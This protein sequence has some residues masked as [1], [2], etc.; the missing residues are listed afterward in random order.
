MSGMRSCGPW[1]TSSPG[2]AE[3]DPVRQDPS[4][5]RSLTPQQ[6]ETLDLLAGDWRV[7]QLR[8]GHRFSTDDLVCAWF[9]A[10]AAPNA[11][12]LLDLG[13][14]V[15]SVGLLALWC[16]SHRARLPRGE[17]WSAR[18]GAP[19]T[20]T[21][22]EAQDISHALARR[23][24]VVNGLSS[25]VTLHLAD[26]RSDATL[27]VGELF[28]LV[29]GSPP[30]IPVGSGVISAHP[31][32]A[33]CRMELR[34]DVSDYCL[35]AARV[36]APDG[37]FSLVHAYGDARPEPSLAA[38]GLS[39]LRRIDVAFRRGKA[40][41]I[42]VFVAAHQG[43]RE[44]DQTLVVREADGSWTDAWQTLRRGMGAPAPGRAR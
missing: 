37:R 33:A 6:G 32:R 10:Q 40:P 26:L 30:Y 35:A 8:A 16:V 4:G 3:V 5:D 25:R 14:G 19:P 36:L 29:T 28:D 34:G 18:P 9:G 17:G 13:A 31:Q 44:P 38:A 12:R 22:V 2:S 15:G 43:G 21:M 1:R 24:V 20:L 7:F 27:P 11:Q 41:T 39:L 23:S 42:S